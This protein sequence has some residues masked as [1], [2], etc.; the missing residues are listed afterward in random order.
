MHE[1][2]QRLT[3]VEALV[4]WLQPLYD[5]WGYLIVVLG[6]YVENTIFLGL[7]FP[8]GT[9]VLLGAFYSRL[10]A[11]AWPAV[12]LLATAG[13]V[14][15]VA[16]DYLL[17]RLAWDRVLAPTPLGRLVSPHV[18]KARNFLAR[19]GAWAVLLG[20]FFGQ[21]RT[22]LALTAG[23]SRFGLRR[24][25]ALEVP[26]ALAY[27]LLYC[28]LGYLLAEKL[29]FVEWLLGRTGA[30]VWAVAALLVVAWL[31]RRRYAR[32]AAGSAAFPRRPRSPVVEAGD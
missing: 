1:L 17:G 29:D 18:P 20:H 9:M 23:S 27:N 28:A 31:V 12:L 2:L 3:D 26:A 11:L 8:G 22:A 4:A 5:G 7:F 30:L 25:L 32:R 19:H 24:Y 16:T 13:T 21:T 6:A 14:A 10:G 15:G